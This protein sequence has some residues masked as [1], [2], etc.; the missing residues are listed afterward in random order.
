MVTEGLLKK[1][2][3]PSA[4]GNAYD[5]L[6]SQVTFPGDMSTRVGQVRDFIDVRI[7]WFRWPTFNVADILLV[8]GVGLIL[9]E[10]IRDTIR[11]QRCR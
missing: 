9:L 7:N 8:V 10:S 5:R 4:K 2:P 3:Y 11:H 1:S 6:F